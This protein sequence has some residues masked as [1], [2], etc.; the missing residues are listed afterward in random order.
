MSSIITKAFESWLVNRTLSG[1]RALADTMIFALVPDQDDSA[2]ID[3]GEGMPAAELICYECA[4]TAAALNANAVVYSAV[5][6]TSAGDWE[7]NWI[8]L[9]D[10]TTG[11][12]LMIVHLATQQKIKTQAGRQ[13]NSLVRNLVIEFNG[14]AVAA[15]IS[16]T[17][18]TWQIDFS[19]RLN[20]MDES[21]RLANLD[22]YGPAAF[23][24]KGFEVR[25]AGDDIQLTPGL[26]YVAGLRALL[27]ESVTL[28]A[29][30][31][32]GVWVD[33]CWQGS[34]TGA[35]ENAFTI[36]AADELGDYTDAAGFP[37]FVTCI[38][39]IS[40]GTVT[41]LRQPF[42]QQKL[43]QVVDALDVW[44]KTESDAR[45]LRGS[46]NLSDVSDGAKA[47]KNLSV[48]SR[49]EGDGRYLLAKS[50]LSDIDDK[51]QA[52]QNLGIASPEDDGFKAI[53]DAV[54]W[55]GVTISSDTSPAI[56]FPWQ[57]WINLGES[58]DGR[59]LRIG[60]EP[61]HL[62]G[63]NSVTLDAHHLPPHYHK[64]GLGNQGH[65]YEFITNGTDNQK[66]QW[67][68][69][70]TSG[71]FVDE[72]GHSAVLNQPVDVTNAYVT[73]CLWKRMA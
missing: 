67:G 21:R 3:R 61:G 63:S 34:V 29:A 46:E 56:R 43:E 33:I 30:P 15:Q 66:V 4:T 37:H 72:T 10:S 42:P 31:P 48:Y 50:N 62:G 59:V 60:S 25:L 17:P 13:G 53:I 69:R 73:L 49:A 19:A 54:L 16:V 38:A 27:R 5:L 8:G 28:T 68:A 44:D 64:A 20:S 41:D 55:V 6:D 58:W 18:Q 52:R 39:E 35:W 12:L 7:Y 71:T 47:R 57:Q 36:R 22:Y 26:G 45:F 2:A 51:A 9:A 24:A 1:E 11:T 65:V 32:T 40:S 14:A 23:Q 70:V